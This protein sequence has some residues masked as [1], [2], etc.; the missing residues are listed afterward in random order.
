MPEANSLTRPASTS[1][2]AVTSRA[3]A[4]AASSMGAEPVASVVRSASLAA[5]SASRIAS[6]AICSASRTTNLVSASPVKACSGIPDL[7]V[8]APAAAVWIDR[9]TSAGSCR[10]RRRSTRET[11]AGS[12]SVIA[13]LLLARPSMCASRPEVW[14]AMVRASRMRCRLP[15]TL[16]AGSAPGRKLRIA[17]RG[18]AWDRPKDASSSA[19]A[20]VLSI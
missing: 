2:A 15:S 18:T 17:P 13:R 11:C 3:A 4:V 1:L 20:S 7:E 10:D 12:G 8:R 6:A 19:A 14:V 16:L 5:A 9:K